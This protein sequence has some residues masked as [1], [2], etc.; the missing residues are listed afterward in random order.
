MLP[1]VDMGQEC[2]ISSKIIKPVLSLALLNS[3]IDGLSVMYFCLF[4]LHMIVK[5]DICLISSWQ[6]IRPCLLKSFHLMIYSCM[7]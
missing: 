5:K 1:Q 6:T 4:K 7:M 2:C 3:S